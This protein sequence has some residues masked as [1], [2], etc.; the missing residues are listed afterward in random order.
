M[1]HLI[2]AFEN[3]TKMLQSNQR[4]IQQICDIDPLSISVDEVSI[5]VMSRMAVFVL[6]I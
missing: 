3:A 2:D 1:A 4:P 6:A 5:L